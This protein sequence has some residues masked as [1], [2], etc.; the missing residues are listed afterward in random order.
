MSENTA[1][2]D[3]VESVLDAVRNSARELAAGTVRWPSAVRVRAGDVT[4]EL[5]WAATEQIGMIEIPAPGGQQHGEERPNGPD[6]LHDICAPTV[7]VFYRGPEPGAPP[8]V[9]EGDLVETG[10]QVAILEAMKIMIPV[11]ADR[12]GR[13]FAV[14]KV[15]GA[16][17]EYGEPLF[18]VEPLD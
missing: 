12:Y 14:V 8:F 11:E 7:G 16:Q 9:A 15:D 4:V 17:V 18:A 13:V 1:R 6:L 5:E 3:A 10:Q 2:A